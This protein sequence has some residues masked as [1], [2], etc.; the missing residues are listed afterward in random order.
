MGCFPHTPDPFAPS[1]PDG[2]QVLRD[3]ER[4]AEI[5]QKLIRQDPSVAGYRL[6]LSGIPDLR[7]KG[8]R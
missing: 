8:G 4:N 7:K 3:M 1:G 6:R 2:Q 5:A